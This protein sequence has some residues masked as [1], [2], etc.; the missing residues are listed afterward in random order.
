M[1]KQKPNARTNEKP[2]AELDARIAHAIAR[3]QEDMQSALKLT[4]EAR[5][6][7]ASENDESVLAWCDWIEGFAAYFRA[8]YSQTL[9]LAHQTKT[10]FE[11]LNDK[12]GLCAALRLEGMTLVN[13]G[14]Y[15]QAIKTLS[16]SITLAETINHPKSIADALMHRAIAEE[17]LGKKD[18]AATAYFRCFAL[19]EK[20]R[21]KRGYARVANNLAAIY[22]NIGEYR[23]ALEYLF[24]SLNASEDL[25]LRHSQAASLANIGTVY[26]AMEEHATALGYELEGLSIYETLGD[27]RNISVC[28]N[29]VGNRYRSL[30][31][32]A[33]AIRY[34]R[35]G[36]AT[37]ETIGYQ[38]EHSQAAW[39]LGVDYASMKDFASAEPYFQT[40]LAIAE[41]IGNKVLVVE[42][43]IGFANMLAAKGDLATALIVLEKADTL[44]KELGSKKNQLALLT[45]FKRVYER[46]GETEKSNAFKEGERKLKE[47]IFGE[48][49]KRKTKALIER[50]ELEKA[51]RDAEKYGVPTSELTSFQEA[52]RVSVE[53]K[54]KTSD[55]Q[56]QQEKKPIVIRTFGKFEVALN[57]RKLSKEDWQ[58]KK[59]R[60]VFKYLLVHYRN[61]VT[62]EEL[63]EQL[64][65]SSSKEIATALKTTISHLR[66]AL[67]PNLSAYQ[68][69]RYLTAQDHAYML[70]FGDEAEIDFVEFKSCLDAAKSEAGDAKTK[71]LK[72][73]VRIYQG[74]FLNEDAFEDW[75]A[76]ERES[77][78]ENFF[79]AAMELGAIYE[80]EEKYQEAIAIC[81]RV[82]EIDRIYEPVYDKLFQLFSKTN[83]R[84]ELKK[85]YEECKA[86]FNKELNIDPPQRFKQ[87]LR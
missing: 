49:E 7:A 78:N 20:L 35:K 39:N 18:E 24:E 11:A 40:A 10:R 61:A 64:W 72:Q 33:N 12:L 45:E 60:D 16:Q 47:E 65:Q 38:K 69:S 3:M 32:Y 50:Y 55:T 1:P 31:D 76:F 15:E 71:K 54:F 2:T 17:N 81:R 23:N 74:Y 75:V 5:Q 14:N 66:K 70:D 68:P 34:H 52:I 53:Q 73:A 8:D 25:G 27:K 79:S 57:G 13:Q 9:E 62:T 84:A 86:A 44:S 56:P 63:A 22:F 43:Q 37:A 4:E 19:Y 48:E 82:L 30:G 29:N 80:Q 36:L 42:I 67:E 46:L 58:R 83:Q 21:D 6:Q 87:Y 77:L 51:R 41:Q 85:L 59:V 26:G 28:L